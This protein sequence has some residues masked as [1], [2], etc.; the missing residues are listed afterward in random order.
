MLLELSALLFLATPASAV[1]VSSSTPESAAVAPVPACEMPTLTARNLDD[2]LATWYEDTCD[3][4]LIVVEFSTER[5]IQNPEAYPD[6][7]VVGQDP[8]PGADLLDYSQATITVFLG[9]VPEVDTGARG[10]VGA[11]AEAGAPS[12]LSFAIQVV[13]LI[14]VLLTFIVVVRSSRKR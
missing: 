14:L 9:G 12:W 2:A 7:L 8:P 11:V 4:E 3:T 6:G 1:T 10:G 5:V 13:T